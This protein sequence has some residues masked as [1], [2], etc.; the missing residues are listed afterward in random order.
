MDVTVAWNRLRTIRE[1]DF[2][3]HSRSTTRTGWNGQGRGTVQVEQVDAVTMLFYEN[4]RWSPEGSRELAF[5]NIFRWTL[6]PEGRHIRLTH[7]RFGPGNPVYLFDLVPESER[8]LT[9]AEPHVCQEDIYAARMEVGDEAVHLGWTITGPRKDER[10]A[11]S[12]R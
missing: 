10:I 1:L 6:D 12:Y 5:N 11:Y 3:A 7:L 8:V 9:S 4:G 2:E